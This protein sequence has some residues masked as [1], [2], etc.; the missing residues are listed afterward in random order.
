[1]RNNVL[2]FLKDNIVAIGTGIVGAITTGF[3]AKKYILKANEKAKEIIKEYKEE[4]EAIEYVEA[5]ISSGV[6]TREE[7]DYSE[8]DANT[9]ITMSKARKFSRLFLA[10][11]RPIGVIVLSIGSYISMFYIKNKYYKEVVINE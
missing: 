5:L 6:K 3:V 1:M 4:M 7:L 11:I 8:E 2:N 9:D 10:Y